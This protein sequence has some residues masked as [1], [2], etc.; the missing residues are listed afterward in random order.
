MKCHPFLNVVD[1]SRTVGPSF[2]SE[3]S[4]DIVAKLSSQILILFLRKLEYPG[5]SSILEYYSVTPDSA[6]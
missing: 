5:K 1:Q 4:V 2:I 3:V 6:Y